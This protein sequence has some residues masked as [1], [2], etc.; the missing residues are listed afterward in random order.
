MKRLF[1]SVIGVLLVFSSAYPVSSQMRIAVF[2]FKA[3]SGVTEDEAST[4]SDYLQSEFVNLGAFEVIT[5]ND[6]DVIAREH[7]IILSGVTGESSERVRI[8]EILNVSRAITGSVSR[9]FGKIVVSVDLIDMESG[10]VILSQ[11]ITVENESQIYNQLKEL[12]KKMAIAATEYVTPV[13]LDDIN[14]LIRSGS[15][16]KAQSKLNIYIQQNGPSIETA[17]LEKQIDKG[18]A[19]IHYQQART[20][21]D[22]NYYDKATSEIEQAIS[23]DPANRTYLDYQTRIRNRVREV[24]MQDQLQ[25]ERDAEARRREQ[26]RAEAIRVRNQHREERIRN[27]NNFWNGRRDDLAYTGLYVAPTWHLGS[28]PVMAAQ[29]PNLVGGT[30]QFDWELKE[31][32]SIYVGISYIGLYGNSPVELPAYLNSMLI[33]QTYWEN[34]FRLHYCLLTIFDFYAFAGYNYTY[35]QEN[36]SDAS[37]TVKVGSR[38]LGFHGGGGVRIFI[39]EHFGLYGEYAYQ[40]NYLGAQQANMGASQLSAGIYIGLRDKD[41]GSRW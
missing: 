18:L 27:W 6:L 14:E 29:F 26:A 10:K 35:Y 25:R 8:G 23:L 36:M 11:S 20:F 34:G 24:Q 38:G 17:D 7:Q 1:L 5:R 12:A 33:S 16:E 19:E 30:V 22:S 2:D 3:K 28:N 4:V 41:Y 32:L 13:S 31:F 39:G 21:F 15:F 37:N 40:L 9:V